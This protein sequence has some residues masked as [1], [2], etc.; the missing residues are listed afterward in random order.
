MLSYRSH[1]SSLSTTTK[2]CLAKTKSRC[3][4][5]VKNVAKHTPK[6]RKVKKKRRKV[7]IPFFMYTHTHKEEE[8]EE[9]KSDLL[10]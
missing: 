1:L 2:N 10:K 7:F 9:V 8:E 3:I 5:Q 4:R 6:S